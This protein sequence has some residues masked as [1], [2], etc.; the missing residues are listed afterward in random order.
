MTGVPE[1]PIA[2]PLLFNIYM[3]KFDLQV[4]EMINNKLIEINTK[5]NRAEI[6]QKALSIRYKKL[7]MTVI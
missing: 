2:I 3:H 1:G 6:S 5:E 4:S 7:D